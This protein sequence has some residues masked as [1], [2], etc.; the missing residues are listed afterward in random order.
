[1]VVRERE[2]DLAGQPD[3]ARMELVAD[4]VE[5][6]R[7]LADEPAVDARRQRT[8]AVPA[9]AAAE[10][11][12]ADHDTEHGDRRWPPTAWNQTGLSGKKKASRPAANA[13]TAR[14]IEKNV[15]LASSSTSSASAATNQ[16]A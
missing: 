9:E 8:L 11:R 3:V 14:K 1:M 16:I 12:A 10:E 6:Q 13:P 7:A 2:P 5:S 4:L 15:V